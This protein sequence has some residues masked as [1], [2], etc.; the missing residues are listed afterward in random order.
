MVMGLTAMTGARGFGSIVFDTE[1]DPASRI[2]RLPEEA[3]EIRREVEELL[4]DPYRIDV[5]DW[6]IPIRVVRASAMQH[7]AI[8]NKTSLQG[9]IPSSVRALCV[10]HEAK[11]PNMMGRHLHSREFYAGEGVDASQ[12]PASVARAK[13]SIQ[14]DVDEILLLEGLTRQVAAAELAKELGRSFLFLRDYPGLD[15]ATEAGFCELCAYLWVRH[16]RDKALAME[17]GAIGEME[18]CK[19]ELEDAK[20]FMQVVQVMSPPSPP[21]LC[22]PS[23]LFMQAVQVMSHPP[24]PPLCPPSSCP[25]SMLRS[26]T[27]HALGLAAAIASHP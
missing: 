6:D 18:M 10:K 13:R 9:N 24:F 5:R 11:L 15:V 19:K 25:P 1:V 17:K 27:P 14:R 7:A 20:A 26:G 4:S 21:P 8:T 3:R 12:L 2:V 16:E 22:P 23:S